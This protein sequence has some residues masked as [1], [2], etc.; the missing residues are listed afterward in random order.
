MLI[1]FDNILTDTE[2][3]TFPI[4]KADHVTTS[5]LHLIVMY[6]I[7]VWKSNK[8]LANFQDVPSIFVLVCLFWGRY[9]FYFC[10]F[11]L[12]MMEVMTCWFRV[13]WNL[14]MK[15]SDITKCSYDK[16]ILLVPALYISL[17][18]FFFCWYNEKPDTGWPRKNATPTIT[19]FKEIRY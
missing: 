2:T 6:F 7:C 1:R 14:V 13:Q 11:V 16:V 5:S 18:F 12:G 19:N 17:F 4:F 8:T 3:C 10:L 9:P 15:R